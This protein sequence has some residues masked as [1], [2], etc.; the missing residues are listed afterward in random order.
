M[1]DPIARAQLD[2]WSALLVKL[3]I[4]ISTVQVLKGLGAAHFLKDAVM[5]QGQVPNELL[6]QLRDA[7]RLGA[8]TAAVV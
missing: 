2:A 7:A 4:L 8:A 1:H 3:K 5:K 6:L